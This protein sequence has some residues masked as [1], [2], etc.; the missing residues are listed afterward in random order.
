M[1]A[2]SNSKPLSVKAFEGR[3]VSGK[4][5]NLFG[6][7]LESFLCLK[8]LNEIYNS[9][10]SDFSRSDCNS[11]LFENILSNLGVE[12]EVAEK[13]AALLGCNPFSVRRKQLEK[14][15]LGKD[16]ETP[17]VSK[18]G[19]YE[20]R[21]FSPNLAK[22]GIA[23][24]L[25]EKARSSILPKRK[26][27]KLPAREFNLYR[28]LVFL[29]LFD[30]VRDSFI[31]KIDL[32]LERETDQQ[33][34]SKNF[35][36]FKMRFEWFLPKEENLSP[37]GFSPAHLFAVFFQVRRAFYNIFGAIVGSISNQF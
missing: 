30:E 36:S 15:I 21:T 1:R 11:S 16:Y 26:K 20:R 3:A 33:D 14:E 24:Q 28:D 5:L 34:Y 7:R 12:L 2:E 22:L 18:P 6:K 29:T 9:S 31:D 23:G 13:L 10:L 37:T 27:G 17:R 32:A 4:I 35:R 8:E 25:A 19:E